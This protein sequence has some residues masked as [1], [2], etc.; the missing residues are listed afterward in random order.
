MQQ[1]FLFRC[2]YFFEKPQS[3]NVHRKNLAK[4]LNELYIEPAPTTLFPFDLPNEFPLT[5][6]VS[7]TTDIF[8]TCSGGRSN[9]SH[10]SFKTLTPQPNK[11]NGSHAKFAN[12]VGSS[13]D[14]L[15]EICGITKGILTN[16]NKSKDELFIE[17]CKRAGQRPK[18]KDIY[19]IDKTQYDDVAEDSVYVVDSYGSLR[20]QRR[21][22]GANVRKPSNIYNSNQSLKDVNNINTKKSYPIKNIFDADS[23]GGSTDTGAIF[24]NNRVDNYLAQQRNNSRDSN[25]S[26]YQSRT[27]PR[28]FMKRN[29]D[30]VFDDDRLSGRRVSASGLY[31]PYSNSSRQL[32]ATASTHPPTISIIGESNKSFNNNNNIGHSDVTA[33]EDFYKKSYD[34]LATRNSRQC[35]AYTGGEETLTVQWPNAIPGSPSSFSNR[36]QFRVHNGTVYQQPQQQQQ[37][38]RMTTFYS[39]LQQTKPQPIRNESN[40]ENDTVVC[41]DGSLAGSEEYGTFD[42]DRIEK[43]RRKSHA[44]LFEIDFINGTPV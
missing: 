11:R 10:K 32:A 38:P 34:A 24:L 6:S 14:S 12:D 29:V 22:S 2:R 7:T 15:N 30:F 35:D 23:F 33:T 17:F 39:Q 8:S 40:E 19:F 44:S 41:D 9:G 20:R 42:L 1:H 27:L 31:T 25:L 16:R 3:C 18:P 28:D 5:R 26:L 13:R 37:P 21:N 43:E 4:S 36:S